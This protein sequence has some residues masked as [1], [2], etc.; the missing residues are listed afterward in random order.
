MVTREPKVPTRKARE[1]QKLPLTIY[2]TSNFRN[3]PKEWSINYYARIA[4]MSPKNLILDVDG[5]FTTG[6]FLY[7]KEGKFAKVFGP[8]DNDGLK[9]LKGKINIQ[10]THGH[11]KL[12]AC[13]SQ[14]KLQQSFLL[15]FK[16]TTNSV[17]NLP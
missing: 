15:R 7:T 6:Q 11:H 4:Y 14:M 9:L 13:L 8:H 12:G 17:S 5:V 1:V 2:E 10:I 16:A 3:F